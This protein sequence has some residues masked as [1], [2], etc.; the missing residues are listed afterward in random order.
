MFQPPKQDSVQACPVIVGGPWTA[1]VTFT[2]LTTTYSV[3][4]DMLQAVS[5]LCCQFQTGDM[6]PRRTIGLQGQQ[7]A[8]TSVII[9]ISALAPTLHVPGNRVGDSVFSRSHYFSSQRSRFPREHQTCGQPVL[10]ERETLQPSLRWLT[11]LDPWTSTPTTLMDRT[12]LNRLEIQTLSSN[13]PDQYQPCSQS[14]YLSIKR[15][16]CSNQW[17][18]VNMV[19]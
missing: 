5:S 3:L 6:F 9:S 16:N 8:I 10:L 15:R 7:L 13:P 17:N 2:H 12:R 19:S 4:G 14:H 18:T 11:T 1:C